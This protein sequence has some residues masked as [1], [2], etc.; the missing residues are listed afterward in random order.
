M[1]IL[2]DHNLAWP[3]A[4]LELD[5]SG[6]QVVDF[7]QC[8]KNVALA[9]ASQFAKEHIPDQ[10]ELRLLITIEIHR[11]GQFG[12]LV[13]YHQDHLRNGPVEWQEGKLVENEVW[14]VP[15]RHH[16][17]NLDSQD[18]DA[19]RDQKASLPQAIIMILSGGSLI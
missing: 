6:E 12:K 19:Q 15:H 8:E 5:E 16:L 14:L 2:P 1:L 10:F 7:G 17:K 9:K 18:K 13:D 4:V 3:H 11:L